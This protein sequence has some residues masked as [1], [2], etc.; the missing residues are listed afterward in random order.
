M[1][2]RI[3]RTSRRCR[4]GSIVCRI[5]RTSRRCRRGL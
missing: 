1:M 5:S 3:S 2:C 4:R